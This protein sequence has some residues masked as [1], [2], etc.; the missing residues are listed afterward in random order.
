M[1]LPDGNNAANGTANAGQK[2]KADSS[3]LMLHCAEHLQL[4]GGLLLTLSQ[5]GH[6][7][8]GAGL[9]PPDDKCLVA[10]QSTTRSSAA[11]Q[12]LSYMQVQ[13]DDD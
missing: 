5:Q 2:L 13:F 1:H 9:I 12:L 11:V 8:D 3:E 6:V 4:A 7:G 10:K